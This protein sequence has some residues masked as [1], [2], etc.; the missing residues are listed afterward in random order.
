MRIAPKS[1]QNLSVLIVEDEPEIR[2]I[3]KD[4]LESMKCW[5]FIVEADN[6]AAALL[7]VENQTFDLI[8]TDLLM[9]KGTGEDLLKNLRVREKRK[10]LPPTPVIVLSAKLTGES[11]ENLRIMG[12]KHFLAKPCIGESLLEKVQKIME[13]EKPQKLKVPSKTSA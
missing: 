4:L 12:V 13:T 6:G 7:K 11:I 9:P 10:K 2:E 5:S 8:I 1:G 3:L